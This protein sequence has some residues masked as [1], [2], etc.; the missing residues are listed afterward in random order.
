[1]VHPSTSQNLTSVWRRCII[2][3]FL[4]RAWQASLG[5]RKKG[6]VTTLLINIVHVD[7]EDLLK[8]VYT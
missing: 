5:T 6:T 4:K 1:M 8:H 2:D 3:S 7:Q